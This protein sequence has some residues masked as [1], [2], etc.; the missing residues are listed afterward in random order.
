[1]ST[2]NLE[3]DQMKKDKIKQHVLDML[4]DSNN[5]MLKKLD[6]LFEHGDLDVNEWDDSAPM[7]LPKSIVAALLNHESN[8]YLAKGTMYEKIVKKN[9]QRFSYFFAW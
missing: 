1:M 7:V 9:I 4:S 5:H 2:E 8:Q 3:T 6:N